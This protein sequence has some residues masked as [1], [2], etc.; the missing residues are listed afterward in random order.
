MRRNGEK[1]RKLRQ[2]YPLQNVPKMVECFTTK[3]YEG[4]KG[5]DLWDKSLLNLKL[6]FCIKLTSSITFRKL[7]TDR[8]KACFQATPDPWKRRKIQQSQACMLVCTRIWP[9]NW[10]WKF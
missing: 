10:Q 3:I 1:S 9:L 8:L 4:K 5:T 7:R 6:H 2:R